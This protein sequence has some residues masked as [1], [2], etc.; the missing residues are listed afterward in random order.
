MPFLQSPLPHQL[1]WTK[2]VSK[3]GWRGVWIAHG[4]AAVDDIDSWA[5]NTVADFVILDMHGLAP[6]AKWPQQ[7]HECIA[8]YD[9]IQNLVPADKIILAG[10]S[11]GGCLVFNALSG[12]R[13][14]GW[15]RP[16][17]AATI[18]PWVRL[19]SDAATLRTLAETDWIRED[20]LQKCEYAYLPKGVNAHRPDV[21]PFYET[22]FKHYPPLL[23]T[24]GTGE[25]M[26]DD[27]KAFVDKVRQ[28]HIDVEVLLRENM[29]HKWSMQ[30]IW[31]HSLQAWKDDN[32]AV[33][34]WIASRV[35][36]S[37][38]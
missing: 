22:S 37:I 8:A 2:P 30:P 26:L 34:Q 13:E 32:A 33:A 31:C 36:H 17:A 12:I 20:R 10:D 11:A 6:N 7:Q 18:S 15:S 38:S 9:Y 24:Y 16:A 35:K 23:V 21:S 29:P 1:E 5:E 3:N 14:K 28:D 4:A 27:I 25:I 19:C